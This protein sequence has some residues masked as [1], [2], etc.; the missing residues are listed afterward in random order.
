MRFLTDPKSFCPVK[1]D[2][3]L[4]YY[5]FVVPSGRSL[6]SIHHLLTREWHNCFFLALNVL[7]RLVRL[8]LADAARIVHWDNSGG[9]TVYSY[10][11]CLQLVPMHATVYISNTAAVY[12]MNETFILN[13]QKS[14]ITCRSDWNCW[15]WLL[16]F[17]CA[18]CASD[19]QWTD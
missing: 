8:H 12:D 14:N 18:K 6:Y 15:F 13:S 19:G 7:V 3:F 17:F 1:P 5:L 16:S 9:K 4:W 10:C 2:F 11:I